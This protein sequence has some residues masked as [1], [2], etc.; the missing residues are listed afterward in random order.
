MFGVDREYAPANLPK[1]DYTEAEGLTLMNKATGW[2]NQFLCVGKVRGGHFVI[3]CFRVESSDAPFRC[4]DSGH[5][6]RFP[7]NI[8]TDVA[9]LD[10]D[11]CS[12]R[13]SR[14]RED[15]H[16]VRPPPEA[17]RPSTQGVF[18]IPLLVALG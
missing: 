6:D 10:Y 18:L 14:A 1:L 8:L 2:H 4:P 17:G 12:N 11:D 5:P 3:C 9:Y 7:Q 15:P 13:T 16:G